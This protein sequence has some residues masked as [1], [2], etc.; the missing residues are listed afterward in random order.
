M[1]SGLQLDH[2]QLDELVMRANPDYDRKLGKI[3]YDVTPQAE[4][5]VSVEDENRH[6]LH[7]RLEVKARPRRKRQLPYELSIAATAFFATDEDLPQEKKDRL[8]LLNGSAILVGLLRAH[9]AQVTAMGPYRK[10]LLEPINLVETLATRDSAEDGERGSAG[11]AASK[12]KSTK[13]ATR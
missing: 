11:T 4:A 5:C 2:Y 10:V 9:L 3:E 7:L 1:S 12:L 13:S 8:I 6:K